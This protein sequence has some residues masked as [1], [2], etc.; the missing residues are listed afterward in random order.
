MLIQF[1]TATV[2]VVTSFFAIACVGVGA[3]C[4]QPLPGKP[5]AV[6][7]SA[8][9]MFAAELKKA[10]AGDAFSQFGVG[11]YYQA[12]DG[13]PQ[14]SAKAA[15]WY[16]K[17]AVQGVAFA[18]RRLG[19]MYYEGEGVSKDLAQA[20]QWYQMAATQGYAPAQYALGKMYH[21][22][23]GVTKDVAK[24]IELYQ[25]AAA[26]GHPVAMLR[27]ARIYFDGEGAP[28]DL[29]KAAEWFQRAA[30]AGDEF[31]Q[32]FVGVMYDNGIGVPRDTSKA[33][34]WYRMAAERGQALAQTNLGVKYLMGVDVHKDLPQAVAWFQKA[35]AQGDAGAQFKLGFMYMK[36]NGVPIDNV[37]AYAWS[38][39][40]AASGDKDMSILRTL[41]EPILSSS[42]KSEAQ[43]LSSNWKMGQT[44]V[45]EGGAAK[46]NSSTPTT[47]GSLHKNSTGT[48]FVISRTGYAITNQHVADGCTELRIQGR[49]G[50]A[51]LVTEDKVNDLALV[52]VQGNF[53]DTAAIAT[54]PEKLRQGEDI[55]VFGFPLN[56]LLSTGGNL[57]PGVVSALTGL[58]NNTSQIQITA[59][60]QPGSSGSPVLNRKG[61]VVG[62]VSMK[63]S[64]SKMVKATGSVAQNVN[65]AVKVSALIE[66]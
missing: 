9:K 39:L 40:A 50:V 25:M 61:E 37:L 43:R 19:A 17:A 15:E 53:T 52:Q 34:E 38:N 28:K 5:E 59:P 46:A 42:E 60:I 47:L 10:N 23:E 3:I 32:F 13:V 16:R 18:Q 12:G 41:L 56:S 24:A 6:K 21:T 27:I 48:L 45:R 44:F 35:A 49:D 51:K 57:T 14:D 66:Y 22:G 62:V 65:F 36:G 4:A 33:I 54:E 20:A 8:A 58:G 29:V 1:R 7:A 30:E 55:I 31:G 63:L 11:S 26:Q 2:K 64:D